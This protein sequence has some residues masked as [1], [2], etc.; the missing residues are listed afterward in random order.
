[1]LHASAARRMCVMRAR[2]RYIGCLHRSIGLVVRVLVQTGGLTD[3]CLPVRCFVTGVTR[4]RIG[5]RIVSGVRVRR[6]LRTGIVS[7]VV[8]AAMVVHGTLSAH[9]VVGRAPGTDRFD[10]MKT[11]A[12]ERRTIFDRRHAGRRIARICGAGKGRQQRCADEQRP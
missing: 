6:P 11:V 9:G 1:M 12:V 5:L 3:D 7:T 8:M 10:R 4:V 2:M